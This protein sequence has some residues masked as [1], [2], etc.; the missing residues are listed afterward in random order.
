ME[1]RRKELEVW[2]EECACKM[3]VKYEPV[4]GRWMVE[5]CECNDDVLRGEGSADAQYTAYDEGYAVG[6]DDGVTDIKDKLK[7]VIK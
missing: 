1:E 7:E 5:R 3:D 4:H 2:C 6:F